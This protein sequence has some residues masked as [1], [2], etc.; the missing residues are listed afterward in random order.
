MKNAV[1]FLKTFLGCYLRHN[2]RGSLVLMQI[3]LCSSY[4][5]VMTPLY[6]LLDFGGVGFF[7]FVFLEKI[8]SMALGFLWL[9]D[10]CT[11]KIV[12]LKFCILGPL[13]LS[14]SVKCY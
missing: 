5:V 12:D 10:G 1:Q 7:L 8:L 6:V 2:K 4:K 14:S 3:L 11:I 9:S 13:F